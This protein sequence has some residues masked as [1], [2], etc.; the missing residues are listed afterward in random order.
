MIC[1]ICYFLLKSNMSSNHMK[2]YIETNI[3]TVY[4]EIDAYI[5]KLNDEK[6]ITDFIENGK[7]PDRL[8]SRQK[9]I[10]IP[11]LEDI[12]VPEPVPFDTSGYIVKFNG[13]IHKVNNIEM[14]LKIDTTRE[15]R[16]INE[17]ENK[18]NNCP[19]C[20]DD[21]GDRNYMVP[22]CGHKVCMTCVMKNMM[23]NLDS[24]NVCCLCRANI[25][26]TL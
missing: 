5:Q 23:T 22:K 6:E 4:D 3:D 16:V 12:S 19:M 25:L 21:M 10:Y 7:Y 8:K 24:G 17:C 1:H 9:H 18:D 13:M 14:E 20:M 15:N 11:V 2:I 26:P